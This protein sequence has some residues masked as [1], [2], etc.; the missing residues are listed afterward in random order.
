MDKMGRVNKTKCIC[1]LLITPL[2][3][4]SCKDK[5]QNQE[6]SYDEDGRIL[7]HTKIQ[8][9]LLKDN[10]ENATLYARGVEEL[11]RPLTPTFS[12]DGDKTY[13][14]V[15]LSEASDYSNPQIY[16]VNKSEVSFQ[17]L[18]IDTKYYFKA[19]CEGIVV[20]EDCFTISDEI[21]RNLYISGV[22]NARDLGGYSVEGGKIKQGLIYRTGRLNENSVTTVKNKI[23]EKG[24][25]TMTEQL[26]VKSEID[27][28][29][30]DNNEVG[31]L[32][33][34]VGVLGESVK[35]YQCPM[36]YNDIM[37]E[38]NTSSLQKVFSILGDR[39]NY[40]TFFH[41]SIG[42]DR[43]GYIAWLINAFLGANEENLYRD[44]LFSNLGNIGGSR[45]TGTI[46]G[47]YVS[48]IN[49]LPGNTISEKTEYYLLSK[50]VL[51]EKLDILKEMML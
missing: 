38:Y 23:T 11:S 30:V 45:T 17:N 29:M 19:E 50:G 47:S 31:G 14:K 15:S 33:E 5:S 39:D 48:G 28:R 4:C 7:I 16:D 12:W 43:T 49:K 34:G 6:I 26:K 25:K 36:D 40:P 37:G 10:I 1:L 46:S 8:Q 41:C 51:K 20:H 9:A 13:Y 21:V 44:Y 3:F 2:L 35:Y 24:I 27:L 42:T 18:K 22:T 32:T